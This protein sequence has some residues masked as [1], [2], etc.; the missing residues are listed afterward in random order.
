MEALQFPN[1]SGFLKH[2]GIARLTS[3]VL[4]LLPKASNT[5]IYRRAASKLRQGKCVVHQLVALFCLAKKRLSYSVIR[6][7][8]LFKPSSTENS[9]REK[10][11][12]EICR[13]SVRAPGVRGLR[14]RDP[15][16]ALRQKTQPHVS[17]WHVPSRVCSDVELCRNSDTA[18]SKMK[19]FSRT[20][21]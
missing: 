13:S 14:L 7:R 11:S 9:L 6:Q 3:S 18:A 5:M 20:T 21:G 15:S 10:E 2:L 19:H 8:T 1:S 4:S 16:K 17:W 12:K